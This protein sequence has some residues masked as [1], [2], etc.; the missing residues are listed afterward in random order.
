[1]P[2][3]PRVDDTDPALPALKLEAFPSVSHSLIVLTRD[4]AL[5]ETLRNVASG[6]AITTVEAEAELAGPLMRDQG[7]VALI[8]AAAVTSPIGTLTERL[9]SQFP[10]LVLVVAGGTED[11]NTLT[12]QITRGA[13]YRFL[14][15]PLSEQRVKLFVAAAWRRHGEEHAGIIGAAQTQPAHALPPP[16]PR[17]LL[18]IAIV[19]V[20]ALAAAVGWFA[21]RGPASRQPARLAAPLEPA[22][23]EATGSGESLI[24]REAQSPPAPESFPAPIPHAAPPQQTAPSASQSTPPPSSK[25]TEQPV[26]Q[27]TSPRVVDQQ[28]PRAT[29][30]VP[31]V[32]PKRV[33]PTAQDLAAAAPTAPTAAT[34]DPAQSALAIRI[35]AEARNA[36]ATDKIDEAERLIQ[37][38]AQAGV[39]EDELDA[40]VRDAREQRIAARAGAMTRLT[41]LF[42]E[43]LNQ[44][45]LLDPES[46]SA[47][48]YLA[49][50]VATDAA[51]PSIRYARDAF[52]TRLLEQARAA[53]S[54]EDLAAARR[55]LTEA[56]AAGADEGAI[57]NVERDISISQAAAAKASET[58]ASATLNKLRH[59]DPEYPAGAR[60]RGLDGWVDVE[61]TVKEDGTVADASVVR[62]EPA[63]IFDKAA[64]DAVR[65]WRYEPVQRDGKTVEQRTRVRIR[66]QLK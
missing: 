3:A 55:W 25:S 15:K 1:M 39:A 42:N 56:R 2:I 6:H 64:L 61:L 35:V 36:L 29:S 4:A 10:D 7:G 9:K 17:R 63:D 60:T 16:K 13:V 58:V 46:D 44:G 38:A 30:L 57:A 27:S 21:T 49:E 66:F 8:D 22:P 37:L 52:A 34:P 31:E 5:L 59:V 50:L 23:H 54:T 48:H 32:V 47:K 43:R 20:I 26:S 11:Q 18:W 53:A 51:H 40:L 62:A 14:H 41:Q 65:Q 28:A 19:A 45:R 12:A 33:A 24:A